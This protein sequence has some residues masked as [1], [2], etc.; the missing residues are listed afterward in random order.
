MTAVHDLIS[1][2]NILVGTDDQIN[3]FALA[4][5]FS[6][7][8]AECSNVVSAGIPVNSTSHVWISTK[9]VS[10]IGGGGKGIDLVGD[11]IKV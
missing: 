8:W 10:S 5:P 4:K 1:L 7:I 11:S 2:R 3:H 9:R 6:H